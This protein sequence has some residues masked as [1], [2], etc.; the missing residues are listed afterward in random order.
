M[1]KEIADIP[2]LIVNP[3]LE[4]SKIQ[5]LRSYS[6]GFVKEG[7]GAGGAMISAILKTGLTSEKL[8]EKIEKEYQRIITLR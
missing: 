6:D 5:G 2:I 4:D 3:K 7:V 8:L 1:I